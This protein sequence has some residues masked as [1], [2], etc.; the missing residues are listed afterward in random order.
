VPS[1]L[2]VC[3]VGVRLG[4]DRSGA[5]WAVSFGEL[6]DIALFAVDDRRLSWFSVD[7]GLIMQGRIGGNVVLDFLVRLGSDHAA[8]CQAMLLKNMTSGAL[9]EE[10]A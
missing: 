2:V 3:D 1:L 7:F 10:S 4:H 6:F 5:C 9:P 8:R